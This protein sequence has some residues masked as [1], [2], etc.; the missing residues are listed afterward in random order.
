MQIRSYNPQLNCH[1][2]SL[3]STSLFTGK[4]NIA[5]L[6]EPGELMKSALC[7]SHSRSVAIVTGYPAFYNEAIPFET[8]GPPGALALGV[9]LQ[10]L[11]IH[12]TL[13]LDPMAGFDKAMESILEKLISEGKGEG[14][15]LIDI[16]TIF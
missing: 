2:H 13:I 4:R 6:F 8:D 10:S 9:V 5:K 14:R 3:T 16:F 15:H 11:G 1:Y 7:L 12:V